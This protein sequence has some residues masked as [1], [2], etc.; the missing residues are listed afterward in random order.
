MRMTERRANV[1]PAT[2]L[3]AALCF[4]TA[5]GAS[6]PTDGHDDPAELECA[7]DPYVQVAD[8]MATRSY[9]TVVEAAEATAI[10]MG[11][12]GHPIP[13][14]AE[15]VALTDEPGHQVAVRVDGRTVLI[16]RVEGTPGSWSVGGYTQC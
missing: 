5:C 10:D 9:D 11:A 12:D 6:A 8:V 14:D 15:L 4:A 16:L 7:A 1:L 13:H 2:A 3:V